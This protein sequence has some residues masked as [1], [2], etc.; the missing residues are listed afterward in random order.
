MSLTKM[1]RDILRKGVVEA[2]RFIEEN[3]RRFKQSVELIVNLRDIDLKK[4]E[5]RFVD[6]ISLPHGSGKPA[7]ICMIASGALASQARN[8]GVDLLIEPNDLALYGSDKRRGKKL[9]NEYDF[10]LAEAQYMG[11]VGRYLGTF[12]GPRGK[13][14]TP[15]TLTTSIGDVVRSLRNSVRIR[16]RT[17]PQIK[18]R[19]GVEGMKVDEMVENV[20]AILSKVVSRMPKGIENIESIYVKGTM[21]PA[22]KVSLGGG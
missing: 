11:L 3:P 20:E 15:I 8:V 5:N 21:T 18:C 4:P 1:Q 6:V 2:L 12:L 17:N 22:V 7:K 19:I 9:A 16:V 10:F 14:P 13:M